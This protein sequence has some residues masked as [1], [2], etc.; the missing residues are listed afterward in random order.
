MARPGKNE[1]DQFIFEEIDSV[2]HLEALLLLWTRRPKI[3]SAEEMAEML[4]ISPAAGRRILEELTRRRLIETV[5]GEPERY[6]CGSQSQERNELLQAAETTYR[7]ELVRISNLIHSKASPAV[8]DFAR[9][10]YFT[11]GSG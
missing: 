7:R 2:P 6:T 8:R 11:R 9:A 1:I 4:Y 5:P 10:F 3:W